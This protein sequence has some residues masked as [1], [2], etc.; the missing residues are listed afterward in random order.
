MINPFGCEDIF[1]CFPF[2]YIYFNAVGNCVQPERI[3][4]VFLALCVSSLCLHLS[5]ACVLSTV[6][7]L[8]AILLS[9]LSPWRQN[10]KDK[11]HRVSTNRRWHTATS[12]FMWMCAYTHQAAYCEQHFSIS[13]AFFHSSFKQQQQ[14]QKE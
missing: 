3:M 7:M 14:Q 1:L 4:F 2:E 10:A 13:E 9:N 12:N 6:C 11:L 5:S 8:V